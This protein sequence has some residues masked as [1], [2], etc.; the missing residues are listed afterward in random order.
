MFIS[1]FTEK[2]TSQ[3][4]KPTISA[5]STGTT[6]M[7]CTETEL[8]ETLIALNLIQTRPVDL[9][10]KRDLIGKGLDFNNSSPSFEIDLPKR[11]AIVRDIKLPSKNV[12]EIEVIFITES[13]RKTTPISG[14][15]TALPTENFPTEK[16]LDIIINI[17]RTTDGN[18]PQDVQL[19][20]I[21]CGEDLPSTTSGG[22]RRIHLFEAKRS[23]N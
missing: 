10:N 14:A 12:A 22:K 16:V 18:L 6:P 1:G 13:G 20:V 4:S 15:P 8:V 11:G 19:S 5:S 2:S 17:I 9:P 7:T 3:G 21:V 23:R